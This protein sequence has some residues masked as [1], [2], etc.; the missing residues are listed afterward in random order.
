MVKVTSAVNG[1]KKDSLLNG[2]EENMT[3][4]GK[5]IRSIHQNKLQIYWRYKYKT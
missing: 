5:I 3:L 2:V 1:V 4:F